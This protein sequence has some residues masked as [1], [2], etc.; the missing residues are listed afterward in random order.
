MIG[1]LT[2]LPFTP[3]D[4]VLITPA[5]SSFFKALETV[6]CRKTFL[7]NFIKEDTSLSA[8]Q[9]FEN[10]RDR[11]Q[12][13]EGEGAHS[14]LYGYLLQRFLLNLQLLLLEQFQTD[15]C[16]G[17]FAQNIVG[18]RKICT[19]SNQEDSGCLFAV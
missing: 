15:D 5:A 19:V 11:A 7:G 6:E 17:I 4:L 14:K 3:C 8:I 18:L 16:A 2:Y 10:F 13:T 1:D 12:L 9:L